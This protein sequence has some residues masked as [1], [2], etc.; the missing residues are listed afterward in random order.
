MAQAED[1]STST[2]TL[3]ER[4]ELQEQMEEFLRSQAE[5]ESGELV[6]NLL[7]ATSHS[8]IMGCSEVQSAGQVPL[9]EAA[10]APV[11]GTSEVPEEVHLNLDP[12]V[13]TSR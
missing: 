2:P 13:W 4:D 3:D 10:D 11:T 12:S 5:Q 8:D 7:L 1:S 9:E 6:C